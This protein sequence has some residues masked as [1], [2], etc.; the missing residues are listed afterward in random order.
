[1]KRPSRRHGFGMGVLSAVVIAGCSHVEHQPAVF[2][3]GHLTP[4]AS[5][6][7]YRSEAVVMAP[8]PAGSRPELPPTTTPAVAAATSVSMKPNVESAATPTSFASQDKVAD[9]SAPRRSFA[10][11]TANP[12]YGHATD[13]SWLTGELQFVHARNIWRVRYASVDEE[14]QYGGGLT[15]ANPNAL[16]GF[17]DGQLIHVEGQRTNPEGR[18]SQYYVRAIHTVSG[19]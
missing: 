9:E 1:M 13:Y 12:K 19:S 8:V 6:S 2:S 4:L 11:I 16:T 7:T 18:D 15:I 14:E 17:K 10:D 5:Q 3:N